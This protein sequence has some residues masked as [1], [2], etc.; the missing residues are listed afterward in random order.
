MAAPAAPWSSP[1]RALPARSADLLCLVAQARWSV[2]TDRRWHAAGVDTARRPAVTSCVTRAYIS[3]LIGKSKSQA[4][5]REP[6]VSA[7]PAPGAATEWTRESRPER[8]SRASRRR[9]CGRRYPG[10]GQSLRLCPYACSWTGP[11]PERALPSQAEGEYGWH[12]VTIAPSAM[13][14]LFALAASMPAP[15]I[16]ERMRR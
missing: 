3:T 14:F 5:L 16:R 6:G 4:G 7:N 9:R 15:A 13:V 8:P 1:W 11:C 2:R 12:R 10:P